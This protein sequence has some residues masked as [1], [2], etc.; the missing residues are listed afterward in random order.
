MLN[1]NTLVKLQNNEKY[2]ILIVEDTVFINNTVK[3]TLERFNYEC[4]QVFTVEQ[5]IVQVKLKEY[6]FILLDLN[7][8]DGSGL[9]LLDESDCISKAKIIILT[10]ETDIEQRESLFKKGILDYI[11]KDKYFNNAVSEINGTIKD[12][13]LNKNTNILVVDDSNFLQ[14]HIAKLLEVRNYNV[15][16]A[17]SAEIGLTKLKINDINIIVLD[18]EL[19]GIQG[20][21]FLRLIRKNKL[22][23]KIPVIVLSGVYTAE[24]IRDSLK[25]GASDFIHKPFNV[26]ELVLK[27]DI[28][29]HLDRQNVEILCRQQILN[30]YKDAV[31]RSSI[32]SKTN[33]EG[34][35]TFVNT[36]FCEISGYSEEELLGKP[37]SIVRHSD[38]PSSC[39]SDMWKTIQDKRPWFGKVKNRTKDGGY[40]WAETVINPIV[41]NNGNVTEFIA[42]RN[43][44]TENENYK[45]I[46]KHALDDKSK[47][48]EENLHY[49]SQ[50]EEANSMFTAILKTDTNNIITYAND[51]F[52]ELS[53]YSLEELI[54]INCKDI[55]HEN[56]VK[57]GDCEKLKVTLE[58]NEHSAIVFTNIAKDGTFYFTD[59]IIYPIDDDHGKV[60]EHLHLMHDI[61][62]LTNIYKEMEDTQKE[63][64][65]KMGE[66]GE[67]RS[68]ETGNH[69]KRVAEYSKLLAKLY[70]LSKDECIVLFTA[71]PMHDIGKIA[72]PDSVLIKPGKL[73]KE[74]FEVIKTHAEIGYSVLKGSERKVL[75][76]AAIVAHE[77]HEKYNGKGYPQGLKGTDI[78]IY[79]RIT[80]LID[81]F[82]ALGSDRV[83]KKAWDLERI[84][85][86][87]QE[88]RGEHFDPELVDLFCK[89]KDA[90]LEI[91]NK[92]ID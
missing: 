84:F 59:T 24:L 23:C 20:L 17:L 39:F 15:I 37:H 56:H 61:S 80:A 73:T 26:E 35:I 2:N 6:D 46:L 1:C 47:S 36:K 85:K 82:D 50:Y 40:F 55:R 62:E 54:G 4:E 72:I 75:K 10:A 74:E 78:H 53:A 64:V 27:V 69:V 58:H 81:V 83:Y 92:Y 9:K 30:D 19:P 41:D 45:E 43:D 52:C 3:R 18:M 32:V 70:G 87:F 5:A 38:T 42:L 49:I 33:T 44:I 11:V 67:S 31:D 91:R 14:T 16:P 66:M 77:H 48:L 21:E 34:I 7:L 57:A 8:P 12:L 63:I 25:A 89:N 71:S 65:Y 88:E 76:A 86:L 90:F 29:V 22:F 51:V 13:E 79:G 28:A 68:K 60:I